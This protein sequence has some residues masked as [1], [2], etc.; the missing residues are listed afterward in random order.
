MRLE[1]FDYVLPETLIAQHALPDRAGSRL[2]VVDRAQP[3]GRAGQEPDAGHAVEHAVFRDLQRFLDEND[4]LV[5]NRSRVLPARMFVRRRSGG[6]VELLYTRDRGG[7]EFEAWVKPIGRLKGGEVLLCDDERFRV[8]F[9]EKTGERGGL[10][11]LETTGDDV[12]ELDDVFES[13]GH[14]PLPPYIRRPDEPGDR[15]RYQT[16]FASEK[17][18]VAAPTAGLHFDE[19][20]LSALVEQGVTIAPLVLHVG[21]GTFSPLDDDEVESNRLQSES[22]E[23]PESTIEDIRNAR[24]DGRRVVALGT[25]VTRALETAHEMGWFDAPAGGGRSA[26]TNLFVYPGYKFQVVDRLITNFHLPKSSLLLL[27]CAF[28][29][30]E[31][32]LECYRIAVDRSYR[33][34]SYGDAMLIR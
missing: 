8:R 15:D 34:Y 31:R 18:S 30:R 11:R 16:V 19:A 6:R 21:P 32:T 4:L 29:G 14:V 22:F 10:L 25:T 27:V 26:E 2:M 23:I 7:G 5:I 3:A 24:E 17:G 13:L 9:L 33:F 20:L 28:L 1:N 12:V